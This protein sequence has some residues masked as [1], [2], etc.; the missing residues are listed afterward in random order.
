MRCTGAR[1]CR[2]SRRA[3]ASTSGCGPNGREQR[4]TRERNPAQ[5]RDENHDC[6]WNDGCR[7]KSCGISEIKIRRVHMSVLVDEKSRIIVQGIT[8][9][10]G[11]YHT[12]HCMDYASTQIV[13]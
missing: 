8:G 1:R 11:K 7:T 2:F 9:K 3:K 6:R 13:G 5:F 10:E 12:Y 4:G